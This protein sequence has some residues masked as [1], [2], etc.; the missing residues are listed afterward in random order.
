MIRPENVRLE[1]QGGTGENRLPGM[2]EEVVYLGFHQEVASGCDRRAGQGR[3]PQ[4]RR[5]PEY[6][7][8]D[9]VTVHLRAQN[10]R[11]L[12]ADGAA[13]PEPEPAMSRFA[14]SPA[15]TR[16]PRRSCSPPPAA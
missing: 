10:L 7:Q 15:G 13:A 9:A 16:H 6:E 14:M 5:A 3:R 12:A 11:V 4:R 8:G 1:P 2:V